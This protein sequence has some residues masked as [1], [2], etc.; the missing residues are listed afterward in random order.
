MVNYLSPMMFGFRSLPFGDTDIRWNF[1]FR[2]FLTSFGT[3][4]SFEMLVNIE[5]FNFVAAYHNYQNYEHIFPAIEIEMVDYPVKVKNMN[6][7][8]S[9]HIMAGIQPKQQGF[10]TSEAEFF[11]MIG[12]RADFQITRQWLPYI[13]VTA[14][15]NGWI[16]G[17]EF[18]ESNISTKLGISARF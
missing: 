17:N 14:K 9:P 1:A 15:T 4:L 6:M 16:A 11:G 18:M 7:Y 8:I 10:R 13:E 2:H 5:K 12:S 3:D